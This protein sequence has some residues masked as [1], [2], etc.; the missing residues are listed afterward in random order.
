M[1]RD[2]CL[3]C[4]N[5]SIRHRRQSPIGDTM[6]NAHLFSRAVKAVERELL[7]KETLEAPP[8]VMRQF[9]A[10]R[11]VRSVFAVLSRKDA[12]Q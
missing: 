7:I 1:A 8:D 2:Q 10:A 9:Q 3:L 4:Y 6:E 5:A 11:I 12:N